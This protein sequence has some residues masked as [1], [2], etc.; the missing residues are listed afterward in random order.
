VEDELSGEF[1]DL[2]DLD[3][4]GRRINGGFAWRF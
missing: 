2:G 1:A 4:S 3:L